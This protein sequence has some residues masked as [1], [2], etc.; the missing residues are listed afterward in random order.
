MTTAAIDDKALRVWLTLGYQTAQLYDVLLLSQCSTLV[1]N[2]VVSATLHSIFYYV[3]NCS[4]YCVS[5]N[6]FA[7]TFVTQLIK[8]NQSINQSIK[9]HSPSLWEMVNFDRNCWTDRDETWHGW[10]RRWP[11]PTRTKRKGYVKG[12]RLGVG[13]K[14]STQACFFSF[15]WFPERTSSLAGKD[16]LGALCTQKRVLVSS[17]FLAGEI[18]KKVQH[19]HFRG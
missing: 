4:L 8:I 15:F 11:H 12:G 16:W 5:W 1:R 9:S 18:P 6:C 3:F 19:P 10:L 17:W 2:T 13:V 7:C 14:C